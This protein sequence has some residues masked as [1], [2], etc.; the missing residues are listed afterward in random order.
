MKIYKYASMDSAIKILKS[1]SVLLNSP[2]SFNDP[3][4]SLIDI[5]NEEKEK[6]LDLIINYHTFKFFCDFIKRNVLNLTKKQKIMFKSIQL[7]VTAYT[8]LLSKTKTYVNSPFFTEMAKYFTEISDELNEAIA[9]VKTELEN[10]I[11]PKIKEMRSKARITCFSRKNDSI[12]MWSHYADSHTGVCFEIDEERSIFKKVDYSSKRVNINL[13]EVVSRALAYDFLNEEISYSDIKFSNI[14]LKPLFTK[15][16]EWSYEDEVRCALSDNETTI[17]GFFQ[18]GNNCF[19]KVNIAKI[20][21]GVNAYGDNLNQLLY[22]ADNRGIPVIF[23]KNDEI[24]YSIVPDFDRKYSI[25]HKGIEYKNSVD[26]LIDEINNDLNNNQY[27]SAMMCALTIPGIMG[28]LL[29]PE[30]DYKEAYIRWYQENIGKNECVPGEAGMPYLNGDACYNLSKS[31]HNYGDVKGVV[32]DYLNFKIDDFKLIVEDENDGGYCDEAS[33]V[34]PVNGIKKSELQI[35]IRSFCCK[36]IKL[37]RVHIS[38]N[39]ELYKTIPRINLRFFSREMEEYEEEET[40][41]NT[42]LKKYN[43]KI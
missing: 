15:S 1:G 13:Y 25:V 11:I 17:F 12:L 3:F 29:Y 6:V 33:L 27:I 31:L 36:V 37:A 43:K 23:M 20:Y 26:T 21:I 19:L 22:L 35:N 2:S 5:S 42:M 32:C 10:V 4:D 18:C 28:T 24:N 39:P 9:N 38:K 40:R 16:L 7:E 14:M 34:G 30:L 41:L 8:K